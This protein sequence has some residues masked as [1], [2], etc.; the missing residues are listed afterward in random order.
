MFLTNET[1][2]TTIVE[3]TSGV[4]NRDALLAPPD[5]GSLALHCL[6]GARGDSLLLTSGAY[7]ASDP[8]IDLKSEMRN[9]TRGSLLSGTGFFLL[10]ATGEGTVALSSYGSIH[11]YVLLQG[12]TRKVDNGHL[13]AWTT[14]TQQRMVLAS[15]RSGMMGSLTSGEG[16][17]VEFSGPGIVYVQSHKPPPKTG[18]DGRGS[19]SGRNGFQSPVERCLW[20]VVVVLVVLSVILF[21]YLDSSQHHDHE[22]VLKDGTDQSRQYRNYQN[23]QRD[24]W[25]GGEF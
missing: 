7:L 20:L 1:F 4:A 15:R 11:K 16:L 24:A 21:A 3:N 5:P 18:E 2:F 19:S 9:T 25:G 17:M 12:E 8:T 13:L 6:S 23:H 22:R 14:S 10:R